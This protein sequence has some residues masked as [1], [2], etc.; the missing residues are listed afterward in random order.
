MILRHNDTSGTM[1]A[2]VSVVM[3][4]GEESG[5]V[6]RGGG[7]SDAWVYEWEGGGGGKRKHPSMK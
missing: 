1:V 5:A 4:T 6:G 3:D 7:R 2:I